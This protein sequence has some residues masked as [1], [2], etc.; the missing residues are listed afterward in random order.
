MTLYTLENECSQVGVLP[1]TG[2]A[3]AYGRVRPG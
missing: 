1:E 3:I 2:G